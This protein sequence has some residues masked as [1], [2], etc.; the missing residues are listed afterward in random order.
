MPYLSILSADKD[1]ILYR[2][3]LNDITGGVTSTILLQ[4][5]SYWWVKSGR[6]PFYKFIEPCGHER[7]KQG[8]SWVE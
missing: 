4:Q 7:Y 2:K 5:I 3:E 1:V 8:D 6:K